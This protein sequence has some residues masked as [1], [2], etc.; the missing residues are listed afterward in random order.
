MVK[1]FIS[2]GI[3]DKYFLFNPDTIQGFVYDK[4]H[5][6]LYTQ[7]Y[8]IE[9]EKVEPDFA[10][11]LQDVIV[12]KNPGIVDA[13]KNDAIKDHEERLARLEKMHFVQVEREEENARQI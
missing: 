12:G 1:R 7:F 5:L 11:K 9:L 8:A 2:M 10:D 4:G 6:F 3:K 13:T